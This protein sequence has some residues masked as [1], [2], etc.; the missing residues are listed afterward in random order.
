MYLPPI[1][2]C[3]IQWQFSK[4]NLNLKTAQLIR[5]AYYYP[6]K[7]IFHCFDF[8]KSGPIMTQVW[9]AYR[10]THFKNKECTLHVLYVKFSNLA[11]LE[12]HVFTM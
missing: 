5:H 1:S 9:P 10:A 8:K 4:T 6:C 3:Q 2:Y 11:A 12:L 7:I